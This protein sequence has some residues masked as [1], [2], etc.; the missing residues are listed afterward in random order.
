M[1][2]GFRALSPTLPTASEIVCT[3]NLLGKYLQISPG[4]E[5]TVGDISK[6]FCEMDFDQATN[7]T[8][9]FFDNLVVDTIKD[10]VSKQN[11]TS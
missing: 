1:I 4:E 10:N 7:L 6:G 9:E 5:T 2:L 11:R 8:V 3:P